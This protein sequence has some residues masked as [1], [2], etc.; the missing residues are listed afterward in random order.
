[1]RAYKQLGDVEKAFR[2]LKGLDLRMRPIHHRLE[3]RVR[4]HMFLCM[5]AYYV[6][7]H[8]REALAPLLFVEEDLAL[9]RATRDPVAQA[10][11]SPNALAKKH[12]K[13][14][15]DGLPLRHFN[16]LLSAVA[17]LCSNTCRV[18]EGKHAE[19]QPL[20][21]VQAAGQQQQHP[22]RTECRADQPAPGGGRGRATACRAAAGRLWDQ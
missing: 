18:G 16:G 4:A 7:W 1:M 15:H 22:L 9:A 11:P 3:T 20:V 13:R 8:M 2:T 6:E 5:L 19:R 17:T 21:V 10:T 14:S 12:S